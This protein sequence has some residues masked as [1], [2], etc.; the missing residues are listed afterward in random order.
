M[1]GWRTRIFFSQIKTGHTGHVHVEDSQGRADV[2]QQGEGGFAVAGFEQLQLGAQASDDRAAQHPG[3]TTVVDKQDSDGKG[4]GSAP[5]R[6]FVILLTAVNLQTLV[7]LCTKDVCDPALPSH[8]GVVSPK[9][10][11]F[12]APG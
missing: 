2:G 6:Y 10:L 5:E 12:G 7:N 11:L 1:V 9:A 8:L 3:C 4:H